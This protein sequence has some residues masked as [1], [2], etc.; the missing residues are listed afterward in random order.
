[1]DKLGGK[2]F[3]NL[4]I[5]AEPDRDMDTMHPVDGFGK[6]IHLLPQVS[7][8]HVTNSTELDPVDTGLLPPGVFAQETL[9]LLERRGILRDAGDSWRALAPFLPGGGVGAGAGSTSCWG[10]WADNDG[11]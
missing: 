6:M 8:I 7:N 10:V 9:N 5:I 3:L 2:D 1:V 4:H 11:D